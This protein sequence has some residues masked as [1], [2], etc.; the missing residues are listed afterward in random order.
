MVRYLS[1]NL[2]WW[3]VWSL[4]FHIVF[5]KRRHANKDIFSCRIWFN[6]YRTQHYRIIL[7][8]TFI[9]I[10]FVVSLDRFCNFI[11]TQKTGKR[12]FRDWSNV[13]WL[14]LFLDS[15]HC[16]LTESPPSSKQWVP[17]IFSLS[18]NIF[19][20]LLFDFFSFRWKWFSFFLFEWA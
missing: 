5:L 20:L 17:F 12:F 10:A 11:S 2:S 7:S 15:L 3:H 8:Q 9:H 18:L 1:M 4:T 16:T 19:Y 6:L 13:S 14:S